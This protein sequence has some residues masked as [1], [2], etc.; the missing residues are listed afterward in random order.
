[1]HCNCYLLV[2]VT[3]NLKCLSNLWAWI[4][5]ILKSFM[6]FGDIQFFIK[7][8]LKNIE[9]P[10]WSRGWVFDLSGEAYSIWRR[11]GF[12]KCNSRLSV[13]LRWLCIQAV[14]FT[15]VCGKRSRDNFSLLEPWEVQTA[16]EGKNFPQGQSSISNKK[17][18]Y[19]WRFLRPS[20]INIWR[21]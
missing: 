13:I 7:P 9:P 6:N 15:V 8:L 11:D 4:S 16:Y 10:R 19:V 21:T 18:V 14:V 20:W 2:T 12:G 5:F 17:F 1:M 3:Y